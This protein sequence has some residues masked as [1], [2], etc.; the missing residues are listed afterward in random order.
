M[1]TNVIFTKASRHGR[2]HR[3]RQR[4][5]CVSLGFENEARLADRGIFNNPVDW[6]RSFDAQ[7]EEIDSQLEWQRYGTISVGQLRRR[8]RKR[9]YLLAAKLCP[10]DTLM[11]A[12]TP[13]AATACA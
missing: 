1:A 11:E 4:R 12:C 5:R 7:V 9:E 13:C 10:D 3:E 8:L 6:R 2:R